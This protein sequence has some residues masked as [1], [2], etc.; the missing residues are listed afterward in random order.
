M[1]ISLADIRKEYTREALDEA[2]AAADPFQQFDRWL[3]SALR[4]Q[5]PEPTAMTLATVNEA[6]QPS[7]RV[8]LLKG[9][10]DQQLVFYTNYESRKG[11]ELLAQPWAALVF[12]WPELE[13]QVRIEGT[14]SKVAPEVSDAYFASRPR[15]SQIGAWVSPQSQ[16]IADRAD[17]SERE[18]ALWQRFDQQPVP[19]PAHW[20][21]FGLA[22]TYFEFWQGRPSRL[23][24]RL[25]YCLDQYSRLWTLG[26]IA[27]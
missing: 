16:P 7:A 18:A 17:L 22:P 26:R 27:P 20:G 6:G 23:H 14:V 13:R 10:G 4:A 1:S 12:F 24:D 9:V 5:I 3:Q 25:T 15:G 11:Q 8:V 21:G 2:S 19:R